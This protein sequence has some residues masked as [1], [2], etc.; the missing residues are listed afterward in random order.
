MKRS[1]NYL[2]V[3]I[4]ILLVAF[5]S[6]YFWAKSPNLSTADYN[7]ELAYEVSLPQPN[8]SIL[9]VM[10]YNIGYLSGMTNNLAMRPSRDF[11]LKNEELTL[12]KL[13]EIY[14]DIIG[15]QEIDFNS[16]RSY[17]I[18]QHKMIAEKLYPYTVRAVNWDKRYV[19]FP[20]Y[21]F[22]VHFGPM[23]SGQSIMSKYP[24]E[25]SERIVLSEVASLP[26]Y[27]KAMYLDRLLQITTLKHP[28]GNITFM[29]VHTEAFDQPTRKAQIDYIH[30]EFRKAA[31]N[32]PVILVGDFNS[33]PTYKN[34]AIIKFLNDENIG[35]ATMKSQSSN[36]TYP[37]DKPKEWLDYIFFTKTD[38]ELIDAAIIKSFGITSDHLPYVAKLKFKE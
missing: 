35:C 22:S 12:Q 18:N 28:K 6:F 26:F 19:P 31:S 17:H 8:D 21:P 3:A 2:F 13:T 16:K 38:F 32:G 25:N 33:D 11:Y 30:E 1:F 24:L 36:Y 7:K 9:T 29:N 20:Y 15:F 10:T 27:Y 23:L 4:A 5:A 14:P 37:A 34:S